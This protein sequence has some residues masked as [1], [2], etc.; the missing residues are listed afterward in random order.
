[1]RYTDIVGTPRAI[2]TQLSF[3]LYRRSGG[4]FNPNAINGTNSVFG[5]DKEEFADASGGGGF[6]NTGVNAGGAGDIKTIVS[7]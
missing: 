7:A 5:T 4:G 3:Q 1:M 2:I 6:R